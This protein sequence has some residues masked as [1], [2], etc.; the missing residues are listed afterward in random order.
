MRSTAATARRDR[1]LLTGDGFLITLGTTTLAI[2]LAFS[3][4]TL[5]MPSDRAQVILEL[6]SSLLM[7]ASEISGIILAWR[8]HDRKMNVSAIIGGILGT[9]AGGASIFVVAFISWLLGLLLR[10]FTHWEFAGPVAA[11][12]LFSLAVAIVII[13][14]VTDAVRDLT[15]GSRMHTNLDRARI[16]SAAVFALLVGISLC[17]AAAL[18][19]PEQGEAPIWAMA[20]GMIGA[21]AIAGADLATRL[22]RP[23]NHPDTA[24]A[25]NL[26]R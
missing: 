3:L 1:A 9:L 15:S 4:S 13:W 19:G 23:A 21:G 12:A 18:P 24:G 5:E 22:S 7:L 6:G 14:L 17:L 25:H 20:A 8:L 2:G 10:P 11:L 26:D 16:A